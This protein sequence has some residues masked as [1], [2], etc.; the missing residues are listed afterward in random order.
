MVCGG[1]FVFFV[2]QKTAYESLISDWSSD[3]CSSDLRAEAIALSD[4]ASAMASALSCSAI[5][6]SSIYSARSSILTFSSHAMCSFSDNLGWLFELGRASCREGVCLSVYVSV[7][8][9]SLQ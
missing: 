5:V 2:K 3:V 9:V 4:A 6:M 7:G 1:C 8:S